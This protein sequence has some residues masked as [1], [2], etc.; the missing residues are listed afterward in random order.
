VLLLGV[1]SA[2]EEVPQ[3]LAYDL[4]MHCLELSKHLQQQ[5]SRFLIYARACQIILRV[6]RRSYNSNPD[7]NLLLKI[8]QYDWFID[9]INQEND[10]FKSEFLI[11]LLHHA[12]ASTTPPTAQ[13]LLDLLDISHRL[14]DWKCTS[15]E[16]THVPTL[17]FAFDMYLQTLGWACK[18]LEGQG[19]EGIERVV[20]GL[21]N[22]CNDPSIYFLFKF[23]LIGRLLDLS[24]Y[25]ENFKYLQG[26]KLNF[27]FIED[28]VRPVMMPKNPK[29]IFSYEYSLTYDG[30]IESRKEI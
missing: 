1:C 26:A 6:S 18:W 29:P 10:L 16:E 9:R 19:G 30:E 11:A 28:E 13:H 27:E 2:D 23:K 22:R 25:R 3:R 21:I 8:F 24:W 4:A 20:E 12:L 7:C 17:K 14:I 15:K 5:F